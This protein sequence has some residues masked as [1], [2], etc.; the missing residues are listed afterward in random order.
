MDL[1]TLYKTQI[2][3]SEW[4]EKIQ[5]KNTD[6]LR[7][8]DNNKRDR[9]QV[10]HEVT[11]LPYDAPT[12]FS[13][14]ELV[15]QSGRFQKFLK[16]HGHE[17]C[18]LRLIPTDS[19]LPKLRMR[20]LSIKKVMTWFAKQRINPA[21]YRAEFIPHALWQTWATIFVVTPSGI[22]GEI[23]RG[24]HSEL[25]QGFYG[26]GRPMQFSFDFKEWRL[27]KKN[28][29][30][31]AHLKKI[32]RWIHVDQA[33]ERA[34]LVKRLKAKFAK[35][36][37]CGY[38]ETTAPVEFGIWFID[39][40]RLL[41]REIPDAFIKRLRERGT[42]HGVPASPGTAQGTVRLLISARLP[43]KPLTKKDILVC[44][45]TTPAHVPL[46]MRVGGIITELGGI[47]SH[48]AIVSRELKVPCITAAKGITKKLKTGMRVKIN[49]ALGTI[50]IL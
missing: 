42:L 8:E 22:V 49:G 44:P 12:K 24:R 29:Q 37:L 36:Y 10:L 27:S 48:A 39:Y 32:M 4:F 34:I 21:K 11:G 33:K 15:E 7:Q 46:M 17:L 31:L 14:I 5:H 50:E 23:I 40:N 28:P 9:L 25:T 30:A 43:A 19:K 2:S 1:P 18:A 26:T 41:A 45:M 20:G 6:K 16:D 47:L 13:A 3:L 35:N 38:F